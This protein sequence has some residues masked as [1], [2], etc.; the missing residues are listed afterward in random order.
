MPT[1]TKKTAIPPCAHRKIM[2]IAD[3]IKVKDYRANLPGRIKDG[4]FYVQYLGEWMLS[5]DFEKEFP[6]VVVPDFNA[7]LHN[8]DKT[9]LWIHS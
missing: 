8:P 6:P 4:A 9:K 1:K 2:S 7:N 5:T 3:Y